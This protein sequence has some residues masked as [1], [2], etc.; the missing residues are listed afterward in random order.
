[1]KRVPFHQN[2]ATEACSA[3]IG[4]RLKD[5]ALCE[6]LLKQKL[7]ALGYDSFLL[8]NSCT[9]AL[10]MAAYGL[11]LEKND[12][13][14]VP[15]Y[16]Y[17]STA[18]AFA[19]T[20]ATLRFVDCQ[21]F[22]PNPSPEQYMELVEPNTKAMVV[23]HYGGMDVGA[24][25]LAAFCKEQNIALIEDAAHAFGVKGKP[26][27]TFGRFGT[28]SFHHTKN[29]H[30]FKGGLLLGNSHDLQ[31][32][33]A[34]YHKGTDKARFV[35]GEVPYYQ[36]T[37]AGDD[38]ALSPLNQA[39]LLGQLERLA[40][41]QQKRMAIWKRYEKALAPLEESG[42]LQIVHANEHGTHNA[43]IFALVFAT[44]PLKEEVK[45]A[46]FT[47]GI[48]A[49]EHYNPLHIS[50]F[51]KQFHNGDPLVNAHNLWQRLLRLPIYPD[52]TEMQEQHI[53]A[54]IAKTLKEK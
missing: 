6:A 36:W 14:L 29:V 26:L 31:Q 53:I 11:Q 52:L 1:M 51:G 46:L 35:A 33:Q 30:C 16:G 15:S 43:H 49:Y 37:S 28:I 23:I 27:G 47:T 2:F 22:H 42:H 48:S 12:E 5:E 10:Q 32:L 13:V 45:N 41:I 38:C 4:E 19:R 17:V 9:T 24:E 39:F 40:T 21:P 34:Y 50:D 25:E 3:E 18:N 8:T 54:T 7:Q 44:A 20:G